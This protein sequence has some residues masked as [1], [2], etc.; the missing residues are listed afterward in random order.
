MFAWLNVTLLAFEVD[1]L[2]L[3]CLSDP[4]S[5]IAGWLLR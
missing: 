1:G 4:R 3:R 5:R 2:A